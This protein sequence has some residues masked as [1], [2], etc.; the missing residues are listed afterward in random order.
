[1]AALT[2][3]RQGSFSRGSRRVLLRA[4]CAPAQLVSISALAG[5]VRLDGGS[6]PAVTTCEDSGA[7][8]ATPRRNGCISRGD[9]TCVLTWEYGALSGW[10]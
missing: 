4:L 2:A 1:M 10:G 6:C 7:S 5:D 9:R 3:G 8:V